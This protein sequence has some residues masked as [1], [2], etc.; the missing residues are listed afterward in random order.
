[1]GHI[2]KISDFTKYEPI[3]FD[4]ICYDKYDLYGSFVC[5]YPILDF[6]VGRSYEVSGMGS[7]FMNS[8]WNDEID[9]EEEYHGY[10]L[11]TYEWDKN[12]P[13]KTGEYIY[14]LIPTEIFIRYFV[15]QFRFTTNTEANEYIKY[16]KREREVEDILHE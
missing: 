12:N 3:I 14:K 10:N 8:L 16:L 7:L 9:L 11:K 13:T 5:V 2:M 1:M 15:H 6:E 4:D